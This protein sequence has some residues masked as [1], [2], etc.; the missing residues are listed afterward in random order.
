[1]EHKHPQTPIYFEGDVIFTVDEQ[2]QGLMQYLFDNRVTTFN[3]CQNNI[4]DKVW[5]ELS[6]F[7]WLIITENAYKQRRTN[8]FYY[9]SE[10]ECEV[11]LLSG[12][13]GQ[14][15]EANNEW[16]EG[17]NVIWSASVRFPRTL[18]SEFEALIRTVIDKTPMPEWEED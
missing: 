17:D 4:E 3:S 9:F 2:L 15:D 6:L 13:D 16:I 1:M 10:D 7:D 5:I 12:D 14:L 18:L 8:N 11:K